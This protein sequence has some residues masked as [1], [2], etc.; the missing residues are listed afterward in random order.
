MI[1]DELDTLRTAA[2]RNDRVGVMAS[3]ERLDVA[4]ER[5]RLGS[6]RFD[7]MAT[8]LDQRFD[9][10]SDEDTRNGYREAIV[11]LEQRRIELERSTIAYVEGEESSMTL[12][13]S[14]EAVD[15][16]YR[17]FKENTMALETTV[18]DVPTPPLL[19]VWGDPTIEVQKGT[20]DNVWLTLATVGRS[21]PDSIVVDVESEI[22]TSVTPS[23]IRRL[24]TNETVALSVE[25]S[26]FTAGEFDAFVAV[27]GETNADRFRFTV[28]VLSKCDCVDRA[29]LAVGS[30]ET[31]L[32]SMEERERS[33]GL[34]NQARTLRRRLKSISDDI[35]GGNR[36]T[37][38]IDNRLGAT[39]NDAEAMKRR[40]SSFEPS[41]GRQKLLYV[42][43]NI[44][45]EV[46]RAIEALS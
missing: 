44:I 16:S 30:L 40:V 36:P 2:R 18:S 33:N 15:E 45:G 1:T 43:E 26:P 17:R 22:P 19:V 21:H 10:S 9:D 6:R 35:E 12:V 5:D 4:F 41:V 13:E 28:L 34:K 46:D 27:T 23:T 11:E 20:T 24:D 25:L 42:L 7:T 38:S 29:T 31:I 8:L 37:R 32:D 3:V 39:R 14:I